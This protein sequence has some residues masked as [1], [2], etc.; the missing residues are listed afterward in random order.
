MELAAS[1]RA[2]HPDLPV[3]PASGY[4]DASRAWEG[5]RPAEVLGEPYNLIELAEALERSFAST[6]DN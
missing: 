2:Q 1:I 6:S 5:Q 3:L 4:S